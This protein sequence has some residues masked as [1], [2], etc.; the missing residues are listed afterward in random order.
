MKKTPP[1]RVAT[2]VAAAAASVTPS[3]GLAVDRIYTGGT[4]TSGTNWFTQTNWSPSGTY[5]G[6]AT[7]G[8]GT[9]S[10]AGG[11]AANDVVFTNSFLATSGIG[12]NFGGAPVASAINGGTLTL[13]AIVHNTSSL[14]GSSTT[15][16]QVGNT[17]TVGL[18]VGGSPTA[19]ITGT[20]A[21]T[22]GTVNV[23]ATGGTLNNIVGAISDSATTDLTL[24]NQSVNAATFS[25]TT[26]TYQLNGAQSGFYVPTGRTLRLIPKISE[27]VAG[28]GL[29]KYGAGTLELGTQVNNRLY[30]NTFTG[31][32]TINQGLLIIDNG[33][34]TLGSGPVVMNGGELRGNFNSF[35]FDAT[36]AFVIGSAGATINNNGFTSYIRGVVGGSGTFTKTGSATLFLNGVN[37]F[38]GDFNV[39]IGA[40]LGIG[41]AEAFGPA[42]NTVHLQSTNSQLAFNGITGATTGVAATHTI[43]LESATAR[44][45]VASGETWTM[46]GS[47]TGT[48]GLTKIG[49][50]S[51]NLNG[52]LSYTGPTTL[53]AGNLYVNS[54]LSS[55]AG[56]T[57][58]ANSQLAGSATIN[59]NVAV[60]GG[61]ITGGTSGS[62][63]AAL[64]VAG[65][66]SLNQ[67][68]PGILK[69]DF[70]TATNASDQLTVGGTLDVTNGTFNV[71]SLQAVGEASYTLATAGTVTGNFATGLGL[72]GGYSV[73]T[74]GNQVR[75]L[76]GNTTLTF[77]GNVS[78]DLRDAANFTT[79]AAGTL[80]TTQYPTASAD[81]TFGANALTTTANYAA[82]LAATTY[83]NSLTFANAASSGINQ[84]NPD[85]G[86]LVVKG[87]GI[88]LPAGTGIVVNAGAGAV[89]ITTPVSLANGISQTWTNNGANPFTITG[90]VA[91]G[92]NTLTLAGTGS[93]TVSGSISGSGG[94]TAK[95]SATLTGLN[96]YLGVTTVDH[97]S[98]TLTVKTNATGG[99]AAAP[100]LS[101]GGG[102]D[103]RIGVV[104]FDYAGDSSP[105]AAIRALLAGSFSAGA[106]VMT[107]GEIRSTTATAGR[108]IG[109]RD[110][111]TMVIVKAT[112][113]GD[114]DL[115]G[116][117]SINDFNALA[118]HFG[119]S[120]GRVW[121][122]G[123]FDYDGG[124]SINDFNLLA[125]G[126]G[127]SLPE[128][129]GA[130]AGLL[131]FAAA[132]SDLAAF[133]AVTGV[134][135]T[136]AL[137]LPAAGFVFGL[138]RRR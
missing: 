53:T 118:G 128:S 72:V 66:V 48:G 83:V 84:L 102:V 70:S 96:T 94:L 86:T 27:G 126:F 131:A 14:T 64:T 47:V 87:T 58:N 105:A 46:L 19:S 61:T 88:N 114:A 63:V 119:T 90:N 17:G 10:P 100:L 91:L 43:S 15:I 104:L 5:G 82:T 80:P 132:H 62:T 103:I 78:K 36:R 127:K 40:I 74:T 101:G 65:D 133:E 76:R 52:T 4:A 41:T 23:G 29:V 45:S 54:T 99:L 95:G 137:A 117:V 98:A 49:S 7:P 93:K 30:T 110:T 108:G 20:I 89:T 44:V 138:R 13:A 57:V 26:L 32:M 1:A 112:L 38:T 68:T 8:P 22:G 16:L 3:F 120:I 115:D 124:V 113:F 9:V 71:T 55:T 123:D 77:N 50:G 6:V 135:E 75:L 35:D 11:G 79:N 125:G 69:S 60:N 116:G 73:S 34:G 85:T 106:G 111:G 18:V 136:V 33:A 122:D 107:T 51:L 134:P 129:G 67:P 59:G 37:T 24:T 81:V 28:A 2:L 56:T 25:N 130:W 109:Y 12:V 97:A 31:P 121:A 92:T 39:G 21:F 42:S